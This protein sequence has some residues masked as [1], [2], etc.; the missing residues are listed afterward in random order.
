LMLVCLWEKSV[1]PPWTSGTKVKQMDA[2]YWLV[3]KKRTRADR[4]TRA[5]SVCSESILQF[6]TS[7]ELKPAMEPWRRTAA[8]H[9]P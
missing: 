8:R 9:K 1:Y 3:A 6:T 5:A 4:L 7:R 2:G